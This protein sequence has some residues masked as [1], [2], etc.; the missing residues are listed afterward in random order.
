MRKMQ[1]GYILN[2]PITLPLFTFDENG[3][4]DFDQR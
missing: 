2:H 1:K 3:K 4:G